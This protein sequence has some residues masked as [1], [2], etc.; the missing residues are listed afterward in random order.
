MFKVN[1]LDW[2]LLSISQGGGEGTGTLITGT[3]ISENVSAATID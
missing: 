1:S 3:L 2:S